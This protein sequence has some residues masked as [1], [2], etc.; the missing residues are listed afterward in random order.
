MSAYYD[1][2][3]AGG[4][5]DTI[6]SAADVSANG[7]LGGYGGSNLGSTWSTGLMQSL[8][9]L[10]TGYLARRL[11]VDLQRRVSGGMPAPSTTGTAPP[12]YYGG[13]GAPLA[14]QPGMAGGVAQIVN[15]MGGFLPL[16]AIGLVAY[17]VARR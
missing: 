11:D 8:T 3:T 15:G 9:S 17:L 7:T 4:Y 14:M 12:Q 1:S 6:G 2:Q 16:A 10:G 13:S 5:G